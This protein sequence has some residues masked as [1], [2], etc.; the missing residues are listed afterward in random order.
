MNLSE[1]RMLFDSEFSVPMKIE[2]HHIK[3]C[4]T[5]MFE[6]INP[7]LRLKNFDVSMNLMK[8][9]TTEKKAKPK[10][11]ELNTTVV[12]SS[13]MQLKS[14]IRKKQQNQKIHIFDN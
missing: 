10:V 8:L 9:K 7:V 5:K 4:E 3:S 2:K 12:G 1:T 6:K 14:S 13:T 11:D